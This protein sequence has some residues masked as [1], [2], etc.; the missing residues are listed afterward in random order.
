MVLPYNHVHVNT[1]VKIILETT[2]SRDNKTAE[3]LRVG[4]ELDEI[5][6]IAN[7]SGL[8]GANKAIDNF[9]QKYTA[10]LKEKLSAVLAK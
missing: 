1:H 2:I 5:T 4:L 3:T 6:K 9:V 7:A 10:D 8:A